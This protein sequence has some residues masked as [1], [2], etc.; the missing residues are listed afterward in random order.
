MRAALVTFT[1]ALFVTGDCAAKVLHSFHN[2]R[3]DGN[4]PYA[5]LISD[6]SG[7]LYGTT[8]SGGPDLHGTVFEL[9]PNADGTWTEKVLHSFG[10]VPDG[11]SPYAGLVF[12]TAG[13]LY[14]TTFS[15]GAHKGGTVFELL[16]N[17]DG[18][19][20]EKV[21]FNFFI[22]AKGGTGPAASLIFDAAGNLYGTTLEGGANDAAG[23]GTVFELRANAD[24]T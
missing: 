14:G 20:T 12:D 23:F 10:P 3:T 9:M 15:G 1:F 18:T 2:N 8:E 5:D 19:W 7:N 13:N 24:G 16:P 21:L 11:F 6:A 17:A 4:H 22:D